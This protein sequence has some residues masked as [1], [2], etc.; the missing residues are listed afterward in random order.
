MSIVHGPL[1]D[2]PWPQ[3]KRGLAQRVVYRAIAD[4]LLLWRLTTTTHETE[5][6][7]GAILSVILRPSLADAVRSLHSDAAPNLEFRT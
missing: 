5:R 4:E 1:N 3:Q 7:A 2:L 6:I